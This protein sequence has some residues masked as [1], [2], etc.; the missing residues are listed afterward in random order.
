[1]T[2]EQ[3][4]QV[5]VAR[6]DLFLTQHGKTILIAIGICIAILLACAISERRQDK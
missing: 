1:M 4:I 3:K 2:V 6:V 5:A